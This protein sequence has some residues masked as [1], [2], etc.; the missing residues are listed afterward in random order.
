MAENTRIDQFNKVAHIASPELTVRAIT[1]GMVIGAILTPCNVYSGLKI[2]WAFN[3]SVAAGLIGFAFWSAMAKV[4]GAKPWRMGENNLNQT[5]ASAAASITS[6]GL[7][8]P[9]PA[10]T[11]L[12]GQTLTYSVLAIW[13]FVISVLGVVVAAGLRQQLLLRENLPFPSGVVTAETMTEIH[14]GGAESKK[15]LQI[16]TY[17]ALA[18]AGLKACV[19]AFKIGPLAP[20]FTWSM[21]TV[22]GKPLALSP[23]NI[24]FAL[25][26]SVLMVGFGAIAGVRIAVSMLLGAVV[27][28]AILGPL[29]LHYEWVV[30]GQANAVWFKPLVGWLLW[31][32][33]TLMVVA[34]LASFAI[35]IFRLIVKRQ[36]DQA[37]GTS[38][39]ANTEDQGA[40]SKRALGAA[41]AIVLVVVVTAQYTI[42]SIGLFEAVIA[43]ALSY[44]LAIVAA[45]VSGETAITPIG[46]LGKI[47]Q[48]TF[49]VLSPGN[50]ATNLMTANVTGGS[51]AQCADLMHDLRTGQLIGATPKFQFIAQL[52]GIIT[53]AFVGALAYLMLIPSPHTQLL[54]PEW[55]APA[56]ATWKAVAEVL[57]RGLATMPPAAVEAIGIAVLFGVSIAA[58]EAFCS[59]KFVRF[60]PSAPAFGLG[61]VIPAWNAISMCL[62]ALAAWAITALYP[63]LAK[64]RLV[65]IAAGLI[66]GESLMGLA[67]AIWDILT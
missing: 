13:L 54:T 57:S 9:I 40:M 19:S 4:A 25:D 34:S 60:I 53:G 64:R 1:T 35:S 61:F 59:P 12:T 49:G 44:V 30:A 28:W 45:R 62:G 15:R 5:A 3:M 39:H 16:L 51:A 18:S 56:V 14:Q 38:D 65:I 58:I 63:D 29:A 55:P 26:P 23:L 47:T 46:A 10:L 42:F 66:V 37:V 27:A 67:T 24:G 33:A 7:A 36:G 31:P 50:V 20:G 22:S 41:F 43:V 2:G 17:A 21:T 48:L 11:L 52:F 6:A 8:A 32:G